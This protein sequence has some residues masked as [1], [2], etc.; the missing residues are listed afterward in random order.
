M[1]FQA[2]GTHEYGP[3]SPLYPRLPPS[4][5]AEV[6]ALLEAGGDL[7]DAYSVDQSAY[8]GLDTYEQLATR[9]AGRVYEQ[10]E[11]E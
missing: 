6:G 8:P 1:L 11:F 4:L 10:M 2:M 9:N 7:T 5:A 3:S